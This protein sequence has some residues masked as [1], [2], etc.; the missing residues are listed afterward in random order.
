MRLATKPDALMEEDFVL[1]LN[2][3]Y[4]QLRVML[5]LLY[6][7]FHGAASLVQA[8]EPLIYKN[9]ILRHVGESLYTV[10]DSG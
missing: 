4:N 2:L 9:E 7:L 6:G 3:S 5:Q 10:F 8:E 1:L